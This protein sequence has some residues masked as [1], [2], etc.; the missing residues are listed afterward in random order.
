MGPT[1]IDNFGANGMRDKTSIDSIENGIEHIEIGQNA[2]SGESGSGRANGSTK[3]TN[4]SLRR[5]DE[6]DVDFS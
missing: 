1:E 2:N 6:Y 5:T 3:T 4:A